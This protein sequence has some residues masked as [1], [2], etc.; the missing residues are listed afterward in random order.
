MICSF[1]WSPFKKFYTCT[2]ISYADSTIFHTKTTIALFPLHSF[3]KAQTSR[4]KNK[5]SCLTS[6]AL[7]FILWPIKQVQPQVPFY[8]LSNAPTSIKNLEQDKEAEPWVM[9]HSV[10][11]QS[12]FIWF[13]L[14]CLKEFGTKANVLEPYQN[15]NTGNGS[16]VRWKNNKWSHSSG[17]SR[18]FKE[19]CTFNTLTTQKLASFSL[20]GNRYCFCNALPDFDP[21][22]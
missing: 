5:I 16:W 7:R 9:F 11:Y 6:S 3:F 22:Q 10:T 15:L 20:V 8:D 17:N 12:G 18:S 14:K 13:K 1:W 19:R 4:H 21:I 2:R